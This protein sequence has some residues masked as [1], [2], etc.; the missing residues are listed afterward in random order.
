MAKR[1]QPNRR[2]LKLLVGSNLYG[3][4]DA[5]IRELVQNAWDAIQLRKTNGDGQGGTIEIAYTATGGWFE[6]KDD[7]IGMNMVT[8]EKSF[9]E[10]GED[11][12][13]V[14]EYGSRETQIGY[15]GIGI[16]SV[17]LVAHKFEVTTRH[18]NGDAIRFEVLGIDDEYNLLPCDDSSVGTRIRIFPRS[19]SS[20]SI[21][22]IPKYIQSYARHVHGITITS[23]DSSTTSS[24]PESWATDGLGEV[25][26]LDNLPRLIAGRMGM[27][28]ALRQHTGTLSSAVTV[29]NAGFLAEADVHD[30]LPHSQFK[31]VEAT[32]C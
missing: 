2:L 22:S 4:Q 6:I 30:L 23:L 12:L 11:K 18:L 16:L 10:I 27:S 14:L 3:S 26:H 5:C 31:I 28:P 21:E 29:C 7:G 9:F 25:H 19:D 32:F 15:F 1:F 24:V 20:F 17:F 13:N 8:V